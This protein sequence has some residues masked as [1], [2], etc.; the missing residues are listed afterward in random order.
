MAFGHSKSCAFH[1]SCAPGTSS[2]RC[3]R[4]FGHS[5]LAARGQSPS[6]AFGHSKSCAF[7][8]SCAPGTSSMRCSRLFGHSLLAA[9]PEKRARHQ[10]VERL[11][12]G[13]DWVAPFSDPSGTFVGGRRETTS[14]HFHHR[15]GE[16]PPPS[17]SHRPVTPGCGSMRGQ[18]RGG[19]PPLQSPSGGCACRD[20]PRKCQKDLFS[21]PGTD[22]LATGRACP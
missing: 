15:A 21:S 22:V 7:H 10:M 1:G 12:A 16:A 17:P 5:L 3:S 8:G 9:R 11:A 19:R 14:R 4:L 13:P 18:K 20:D 2:M 6:M